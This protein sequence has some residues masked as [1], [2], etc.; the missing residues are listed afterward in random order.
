MCFSIRSQPKWAEEN[1]PSVNAGVAP[2]SNGTIDTIDGITRW[3]GTELD[4]NVAN[5]RNAPVVVVPLSIGTTRL[6]RG[7]KQ[8]KD[9]VSQNPLLITDQPRCVSVDV[10]NRFVGMRNG[11]GGTRGYPSTGINNHRSQKGRIHYAS[12]VAGQKYLGVRKLIGGAVSCQGTPVAYAEKR[13]LRDSRN[14]GANTEILQVTQPGSIKKHGN[15]SC[16]VGHVECVEPSKRFTPTTRF[17]GITNLWSP[18]ALGATSMSIG[19]KNGSL[20]L[21]KHL[22]IVNVVAENQ[23]GGT[24]TKEVGADFVQAMQPEPPKCKLNFDQ[25]NDDIGENNSHGSSL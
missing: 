13:S 19:A 12:V 8:S 10:V 1:L 2:K 17:L 9:T 11:N 22:H 21:M 14:I 23:F 4:E 7:T 3:Q 15:D 6:G 24:T 25:A 16:P 5:R 18:F 20:D